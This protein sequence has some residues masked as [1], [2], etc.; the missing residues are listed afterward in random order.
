[1]TGTVDSRVSFATPGLPP[2]ASRTGLRVRAREDR[3][4]VA[5]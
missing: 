1:M 3:L 4:W 2:T 5:R